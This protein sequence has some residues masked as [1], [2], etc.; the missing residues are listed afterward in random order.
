MA[1]E[2]ETDGARMI[3]RKEFLK[4][5]GAGIV[6]G[7]LVVAGVVTTGRR[8]GI[9]TLSREAL[10]PSTGY[11][12]VDSAKCSGCQSCMIACST[13]HEGRGQ[14][15][16]SRI[17]I[18]QN[19]F[20]QYPDDIVMKQ[21]RQCAYPSCVVACST[22]ALHVDRRT[23][24]RMV[25]EDAC[26]GCQRCMEGCPHAPG[27]VE[28]NATKGRATKCDLCLGSTYWSKTGGPGGSQACVEVCPMKAI[29][30]SNAIPAQIG[31]L[32]YEVN[33]RSANYRALTDPVPEQRPQAAPVPAAPAA[34]SAVRPRRT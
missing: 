24:V 18:T 17:Q 21:C 9:Q 10:P 11:I 20:V 12:L 4:G 15:S 8:Q 22:G 29:T 32:G 34:G 2:Q 27:R 23:G 13:V 7:G 28:W 3:T 14:V 33:L 25:D 26:I 6:G 1:D 31:T 19:A 30:F 16:L 5:L